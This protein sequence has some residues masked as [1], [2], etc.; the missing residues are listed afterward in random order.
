MPLEELV[1]DAGPSV[2]EGDRRTPI[3]GV[4]IDSRRVERGALFAAV[5]GEKADGLAFVGDALAR[6][7][8]AVLSDRPRPAGIDCA[9]VRV[10]NARSAL[11]MMARAFH[12]R[13]DRRIAV[14]G[15]TG[16]NGKTTIT[17]LLEAIIG[18]AGDPRESWEPSPTGSAA[19]RF[20]PRARLRKP[21]SSSNRWAGWSMR[22]AR[23][24]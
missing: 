20:R 22:A 11:A 16:T 9:C 3:S 6:G 14:I 19:P 17:Y 8:S 13:P 24:P 5:R 1:R 21:T 23:T 12:G 7:A 4:T 18:K 10:E 2:I 15:V